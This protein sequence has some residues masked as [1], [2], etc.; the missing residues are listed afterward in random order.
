[1]LG[2]AN[3]F[4]KLE[5]IQASSRFQISLKFELYRRDRLKI[6]ETRHVQI[7]LN[8]VEPFLRYLHLHC[9]SN[10]NVHFWGRRPDNLITMVVV[11]VAKK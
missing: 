9:P 3:F 6:S 10:V 7:S 11:R 1:M 5:Q 4:H 8:S 2:F